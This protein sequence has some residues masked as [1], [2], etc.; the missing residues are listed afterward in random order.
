M[1]LN[2]IVRCKVCGYILTP[3]LGYNRC[4]RCGQYHEKSKYVEDYLEYFKWN[5]HMKS[6]SVYG[7]LSERDE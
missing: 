5:K 7:G 4:P 2:S 1:E 3:E 6:P